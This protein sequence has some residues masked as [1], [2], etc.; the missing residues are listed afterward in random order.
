[1]LPPVIVPPARFVTE[2][3]FV[4]STP[5]ALTPKMFPAFEIAATD[6]PV[7]AVLPEKTPVVLPVIEPPALFVR[8]P[9]P[10][11]STPVLMAAVPA[12]LPLFVT[13]P[14]ARYFA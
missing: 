2:P 3:P 7:A 1:M 5:S 14:A 4:R 8:L 9:P 13:V 6:E 10:A 11:R 12:M